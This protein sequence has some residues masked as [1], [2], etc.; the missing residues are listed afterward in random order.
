MK[1][2]IFKI[3][4]LISVVALAVLLCL[5][6]VFSAVSSTVVYA[7][8]TES[9]SAVLDDLH[10]DES[11]DERNYPGIAGDY[12]LNV[13][14]IA[15]TT[16]RELVIYVYQ[17]SGQDKSLTASSINISRTINDEISYYNFKLKLLNSDGVF[18]KYLVTDMTVFSD[19]T[20]YYAISVIYRPFDEEIDEQ[21]GNDNVIT[22]V[23]Y[24]VNKQY[25]FGKINGNDYCSVVDIETIEITDKFV[26]FVRYEDGYKF[27]QSGNAC[28]SHFVAFNTDR[29]I[30]KLLEA[31]VYYTS[32]YRNSY[33]F[34]EK[35][36]EYAYLK[37]DQ[38]V[39]HTGGGWFAGTY[40]WDRIETVE[41]F[42]EETKTYQNVYSG[43]LF[44][45]NAATE[46]TDEY[47]TALEDKKWVLRFTETAYEEFMLPGSYGTV[48]VEHY[49]IVGEVAILRLKFETDG[50]SYNLGVIDN[51][52][53]GSGQ[54]GLITDVS[55][56][57][58]P[59]IDFFQKALM[60]FVLIMLL[61]VLGIFITPIGNVL[62]FI[63]K[64]VVWVISLPFNL[65]SS[66]FKRR[67]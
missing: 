46:L 22:E 51:K 6:G 15:E 41:Q 49:T 64:S 66:L 23:N 35:K 14:Q 62:K 12:S 2:K 50:I 47:K 11:F 9:G 43:A 31:D 27:F 32:Q 25:C 30:D 57:F 38:H 4:N 3:C 42:K 44:N 26:G 7:V 65:L 53:T 36:N 20:R 21:A 29:R 5:F 63:L 24:A 58:D 59:L 45:V 40:K 37:Y 19:P 56:D 39:E 13:I 16:D 8:T 52:Q 18:F 60:I 33:E 54:N 17:P 28:D 48:T 1:Y 55:V 34:K 61:V 67:E 10:I